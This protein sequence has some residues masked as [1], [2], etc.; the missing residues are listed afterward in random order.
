VKAKARNQIFAETLHGD[1]LPPCPH[2]QVRSSSK[3]VPGMLPGKTHDAELLGKRVEM[4][5]EISGFNASQDARLLEILVKQD[6][7]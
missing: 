3:L 4:L 7:S 1:P 5:L 6:A 2:T